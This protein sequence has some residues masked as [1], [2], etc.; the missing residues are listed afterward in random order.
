MPSPVHLLSPQ[1]V[2]W[3]VFMY[4]ITAV[5]QKMLLPF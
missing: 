2:V 1:I 4:V 5:M 3:K